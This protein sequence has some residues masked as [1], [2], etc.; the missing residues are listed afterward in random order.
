MDHGAIKETQNAVRFLLKAAVARDGEAGALLF[1][2]EQLVSQGN[3]LMS[4]RLSKSRQLPRSITAP[5]TAGEL[6]L[7]RS[8]ACSAH[9]IARR[10]CDSQK[11]V[12]RSEPI[13]LLA[14]WLEVVL[15]LDK[16]HGDVGI[17]PMIAQYE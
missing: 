2:N 5:I 13:I 14:A 11:Y 6:T 7:P 4:S 12:A 17:A 8:L 3:E 1:L 9:S 16:L 10:G 15:A